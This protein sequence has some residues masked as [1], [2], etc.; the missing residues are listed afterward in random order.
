LG[1][2][3]SNA[4][5]A[6]SAS[7]RLEKIREQSSGATGYPSTQLAKKLETV[8]QLIAAG[9]KTRV[10]YVTLDGFDTH[11]EQA[12]AHRALLE[13]WS[14]AMSAFYKDL[15]ARN[16]ADHV[17]SFSFSE[18]GRRVQEN[19]SQGTDHGAAAPVF[20]VGP[21]VKPGVIGAFPSLTDLDD[22]DQKF[23]TD[24]RQ[25]YAAILQQWLG[26]DSEAVLGGKFEPVA[27][28]S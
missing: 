12:A 11:S 8:A 10:Y 9:L 5:A 23:H 25:V 4:V 20:L 19:A 24:F 26:C 18:F 2:V 13:Q 28:L 15:S 17:L 7:E 6:L 27:A 16:L 21:T 3:Q 1:F 22:G 14:D